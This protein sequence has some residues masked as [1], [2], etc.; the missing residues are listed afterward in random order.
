MVLFDNCLQLIIII[1]YFLLKYLNK[2]VMRYHIFL[3][4]DLKNNY[5]I[6]YNIYFNFYIYSA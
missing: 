5:N 6:K 4:I 2:S 3:L 1:I